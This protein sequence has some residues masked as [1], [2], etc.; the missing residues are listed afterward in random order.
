MTD[1]P[2][3]GAPVVRVEFERSDH[4][5]G[6]GVTLLVRGKHRARWASRKATTRMWPRISRDSDENCNRASTLVLWPLGHLDV[7]WEP[8]WRPEDAGV[9]DEC[10]ALAPAAGHMLPDGATHA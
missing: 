6:W 4:G 1:G 3:Q 2:V 8:N 9:C 7:W 5:Y 10:R